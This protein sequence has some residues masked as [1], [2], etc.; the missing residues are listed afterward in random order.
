MRSKSDD[1][2]ALMS[3]VAE[4]WLPVVAEPWWPVVVGLLLL[5]V[6]G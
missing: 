1:G 2:V 5:V 4:P 6:A 3:V